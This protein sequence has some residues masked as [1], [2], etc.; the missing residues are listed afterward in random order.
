MKKCISAALIIFLATASTAQQPVKPVKTGNEWKMPAD[1]LQRSA[2][3]ANDL[4]TK[5]SLDSTQTAK[6]Y[7][8]YMANTKSV[9]EISVLPDEEEKKAKLKENKA[10]FNDILKGI[11]TPVQFH[12]YL[13][14]PGK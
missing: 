2:A 9:D 8:A 3:F 14:L 13:Q 11:L 7:N 10:A 4:K 12:K 6:V 1:V 5:L